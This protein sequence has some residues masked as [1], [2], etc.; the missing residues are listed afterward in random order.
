MDQSGKPSGPH[1]GG[2]L[3]LA[4]L[5]AS[6]MGVSAIFLSSGNA[7]DAAAPQTTRDGQSVEARIATPEITTPMVTPRTDRSD[8]RPAS[9]ETID[10]GSVDFIV[11]LRGDREFD[12]ILKL[13]RSDKDAAKAAYTDWIKDKD[14][15]AGS[16]LSSASYSGEA[17]ITYKLGPDRPKMADIQRRMLDYDGVAYADPDEIARPGQTGD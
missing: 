6:A 11:K 8:Q 3:G 15:F 17:I 5:V 1:R 16:E 7:D 13:Y 12:N 9:Y 2:Q 4:A 10:G 14:A